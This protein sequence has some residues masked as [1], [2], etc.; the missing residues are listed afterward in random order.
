MAQVIGLYEGSGWKENSSLPLRTQRH[1][2]SPCPWHRLQSCRWPEP[3]PRDGQAR[4]RA[5]LLTASPRMSPGCSTRCDFGF[6]L[7]CNALSFSQPQWNILVCL[8]WRRWEQEVRL[9][10]KTAGQYVLLLVSKSSVQSQRWLPEVSLTTCHTRRDRRC[11]KFTGAVKNRKEYLG[12][13]MSLTGRREH[14]LSP[15]ERKYSLHCFPC[16]INDFLSSNQMSFLIKCA[17]QT[18]RAYREHS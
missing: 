10:P 3:Q 17:K 6:V 16:Q 12:V 14:C 7:L 5:A 13:H 18:L 11:S 1:F 9:L 8:N 2:R 15:L 4:Q